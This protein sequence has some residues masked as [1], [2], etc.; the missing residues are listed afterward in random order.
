VL[1]PSQIRFFKIQGTHQGTTFVKSSTYGDHLR[2]ARGTHK[3]AVVNKAFRQ[4]TAR[5]RDANV[6]AK[7]IN[8]ALGGGDWDF[9]GYG[10]AGGADGVCTITG[11]RVEGFV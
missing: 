1:W 8:D 2:A 9:F 10:H 3:P 6:A 11:D 4:S 5:L 7:L